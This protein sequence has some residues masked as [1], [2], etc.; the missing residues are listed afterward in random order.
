MELKILYRWR[1]YGFEEKNNYFP[2]S[3]VYLNIFHI[4][5]HHWDV[6]SLMLS[7]FNF[8]ICFKTNKIP[9][10]ATPSPIK[11][12][13]RFKPSQISKARPQ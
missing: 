12:Y 13:I 5:T 1:R 3:K 11:I 7:I 4:L 8:R 2:I 6:L 10:S 9:L